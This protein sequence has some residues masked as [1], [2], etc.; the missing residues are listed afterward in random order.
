MGQ[1]GRGQ[2]RDHMVLLLV[3]VVLLSP[4]LVR[5]GLGD[6][7]NKSFMKVVST[8]PS[9]VSKCIL[10]VYQMEVS[11]RIACAAMCNQTPSCRLYCVLGVECTMLK[12][13][14][15]QYWGGSTDVDAYAF[16]SCYSS[17][18]N[19]RDVG[20]LAIT[21]SIVYADANSIDS[22]AV[23]GYYC[24]KDYG[25]YLAGSFLAQPWWLA[26]MGSP[27]DV[28]AIRL[29]TRD[30]G[31][32]IMFENAEVRVGNSSDFGTNP[33]L[34]TYPGSAKGI[35]VAMEGTSSIKG[36]YVSIQL[37]GSGIKFALAEVQI[38]KPH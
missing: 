28:I 26:D 12:A 13:F 36:R 34:A 1:C 32:L 21:S 16:T 2:H 18:A 25:C 37:L 9:D 24:R 5:M 31:A 15:T 8:L 20:G 35:E 27:V 3:L 6:L 10:A 14:V 30:G 17:W 22:K 23:D 7:T 11:T 38:L 29:M 19:H 33:L 4:S